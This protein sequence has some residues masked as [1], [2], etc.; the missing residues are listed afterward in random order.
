MQLLCLNAGV[1]RFIC[2][3]ADPDTTASPG[4]RSWVVQQEGLLFLNL[5]GTRWCGNKGGQHKSNGVFYVGEISFTYR[6]C[7]R[8]F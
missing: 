2:A 6:T 8:L 7:S 5:K 1:E 4:V 3:V